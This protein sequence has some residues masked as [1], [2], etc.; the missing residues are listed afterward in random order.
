MNLASVF[1]R[2]TKMTLLAWVGVALVG[3]GG[4]LMVDDELP[5]D[6]HMV[7]PAIY[8]PVCANVN[9]DGVMEKITFSN[10]C[11]MTNSPSDVIDFQEG[12]CH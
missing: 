3:C 12:S 10:H 5:I 6:N 4:H 11:M 8:H 2:L 7:C 9:N 1:V